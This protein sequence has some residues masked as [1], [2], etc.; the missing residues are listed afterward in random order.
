MESEIISTLTQYGVL[1]L[2][3]ASLLYMNWQQRKE[4][5]IEEEKAD[6]ALKYHQSQIV[7]RLT[8]QNL[9]LNKAIEKIDAGLR[10]MREKYAED[11]LRDLQNKN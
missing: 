7:T 5:L 3:T 4:R 8:E 1:G 2:W 10:D 6:K 11:R 9:M